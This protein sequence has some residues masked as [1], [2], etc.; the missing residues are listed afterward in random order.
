MCR[1]RDIVDDASR[2]SCKSQCY[3]Q[4][5]GCMSNCQGRSIVDEAS[6]AS[7][8]AQCHGQGGGCMANCRGRQIAL[9]ATHTGC[10][11]ECNGDVA[12]MELCE[13]R[14]VSDVAIPYDGA[15]YVIFGAAGVGLAAAVVAGAVFYSKRGKSA[16]EEA[17]I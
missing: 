1:G 13:S 10:F 3:G 7:C 9:E 6:R 12:C 14:L 11:A 5:S 17:L 2:A 4:G 15:K 16:E 8:D